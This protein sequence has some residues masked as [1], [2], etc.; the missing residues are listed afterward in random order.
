MRQM[1]SPPHLAEGGMND[2]PAMRW[3]CE[4]AREAREEAGRAKIGNCTC[5]DAVKTEHGGGPDG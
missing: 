4:A 3:W 2:D 1:G 5:D